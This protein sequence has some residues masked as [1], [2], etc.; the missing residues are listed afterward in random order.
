MIQAILVAASGL[1]GAFLGYVLQK[2][3]SE[4]NYRKEL[5]ASWRKAV[6]EYDFTQ[7]SFG[8]TAA[9]AAMRPHMDPGVV[10]ALER[11]NTRFAPPR[12]GRGG[13]PRQ[14]RILDQI[15]KIEIRWG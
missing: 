12:G 15:T 2:L 6:D 5:I 11:Q 1:I 4:R 14:T 9:Y 10:E 13:N 8:E 3:T 7:G